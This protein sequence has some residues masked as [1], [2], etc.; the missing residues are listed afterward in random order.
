MTGFQ[1]PLNTWNQRFAQAGYL[2]GETPNRYLV[3]Q[4]RH[5]RPGRALAVA[6]GEGRNGVWLAEQG[7]TVDAFDFSPV[8]LDKASALA[9]Q[10][11][12]QVRWTCADWQH[13][14]WQ[15]EAWDNVVAIFIQFASPAERTQLFARMSASLKPGGTLVL[16]G[17]SQDQLRH[18]T[19]GPGKREHLYDETL[20]LEAFADYEVL[21]LRS[22]EDVLA[23]GSAHCG[24]S[25]L[26]G[27]TARKP[28]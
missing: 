17:Y 22:Y 9:H 21:D 7:L 25:A 19:G 2:F 8:A 1:D 16:Q 28:L 15:T 5:L 24:R 4:A 11:G 27:F 6:D 10:H 26:V 12:V 18:N 23:E 3:Q 14:D 13:F 20:L